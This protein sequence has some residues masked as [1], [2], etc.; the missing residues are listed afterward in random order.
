VD[1]EEIRLVAAAGLLTL[2]LATTRG[3]KT[4]EAKM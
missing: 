4:I 2:W 3:G 1:V